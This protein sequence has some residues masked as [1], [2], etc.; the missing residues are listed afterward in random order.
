M[1]YKPPLSDDE[2]ANLVAFLDGELRGTA[3]RAVETRL[4]QDTR[5]RAEADALKQAWD[6]L[7]HLPYSPALNPIEHVWRKLKEMVYQVNLAIEHVT[8]SGETV[9]E[10]LAAL[11]EARDL[12]AQ[13]Y[14]DTCWSMPRRLVAL[15]DVEGWPTKYYHRKKLYFM[16]IRYWYYNPQSYSF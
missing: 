3:A 16:Y 8:G 2:R 10:A 14:L 4:T 11:V 6:L 13:S 15:R 7:D 12:T 9:H 1:S 5:F